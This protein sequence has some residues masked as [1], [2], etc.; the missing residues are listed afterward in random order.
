MLYPLL[1][2][3]FFFLFVISHIVG[4]RVGWMKFQPE[5]FLIIFIVWLGVYLLMLEKILGVSLWTPELSQ[6][7]RTAP[8][9][10]SS[11]LLYGLL[12]LAYV[13]EST[14]V[15]NESP[16]MKIIK[17]IRAS[18]DQQMSFAELKQGFTD[19][20]FIHDRLDD[21]VKHGHVIYEEG[22]Y[23]L[24]RKGSLIVGIIRVYRDFIRR[25]LGG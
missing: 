17:M 13:A 2:T 19:K 20:E 4:H 22:Q 8:F 1:A 11:L 12:C 5:R 10:W 3:F 6:D 21:L 16:S 24:S 9:V 7:G 25:G 18:E 23:L 14:A 15:E